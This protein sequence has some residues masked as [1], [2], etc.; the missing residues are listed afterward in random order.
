MMLKLKRTK[1]TN[2][3]PPP[4][5]TKQNPK[6]KTPNQKLTPPPPTETNPT[7]PQIALGRFLKR[8]GVSGSLI[9]ALL[10]AYVGALQWV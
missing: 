3:P 2:H 9:N 8:F 7:S 5:K 1:P 4:N 6:H 10:S